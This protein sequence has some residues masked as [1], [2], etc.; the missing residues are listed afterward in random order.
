MMDDAN[1]D[2]Q[3]RIWEFLNVSGFLSSPE[4]WAG[5]AAGAVL[6][7]CAIQLRMRRSEI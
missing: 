6:V 2:P 5:V 3:P 1:R 7:F 4:T